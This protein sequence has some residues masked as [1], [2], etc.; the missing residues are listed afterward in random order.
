VALFISSHTQALLDDGPRS[1][2]LQVERVLSILDHCSQACVEVR[3]LRVGYGLKALMPHGVS[4]IVNRK[5]CDWHRGGV[6]KVTPTQRNEG[7]LCR[8]LDSVVKLNAD[9]GCH[10]WIYRVERDGHTN[11]AL[12]HAMSHAHAST[13]DR[14][15][16]IVSE[17]EERVV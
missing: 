7:D 11:L 10:P 5:E 1:G 16:P 15:I 13:V 2:V 14:N 12:L 17:V 6:S 3:T 4:L 9:D 8:L